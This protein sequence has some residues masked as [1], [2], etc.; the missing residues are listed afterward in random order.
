MATWIVLSLLFACVGA[1][2]YSVLPLG[3]DGEYIAEIKV[4]G[5]SFKLTL[6]TGSS[7]L[8]IP[9]QQ[10]SKCTGSASCSQGSFGDQCGC[11]SALSSS[12][13]EPVTC[14]EF[15]CPPETG[16]LTCGP[17]GIKLCDCRTASTEFPFLKPDVAVIVN[18]ECYGDNSGYYGV[19]SKNKVK[20][21]K[22]ETN[23]Y[24]TAYSFMI[25][26]YACGTSLNVGI[27][28]LAYKSI[29][30]LGVPG[31]LAQM[32]KEH[33]IDDVFAMC[34]VKPASEYVQDVGKSGSFVVGGIGP[35]SLYTGQVHYAAVVDDEFY[36]V[37][38]KDMQVNGQSFYMDMSGYNV[39]VDSGTT[40]LMLPSPVFAR[41]SNMVT[42]LND[43]VSFQLDGLNGPD[44]LLHVAYSDLNG[45]LA[46]GGNNFILGQPLFWGHHV[47]F[48]RTLNA[49]GFAAQGNCNSHTSS[50]SK[51]SS[52]TI[53]IAVALPL[54]ILAGGVAVY[55]NRKQSHKYEQ[56]IAYVAPE[57]EL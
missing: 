25:D 12:H 34:F 14:S 47:V 10:C 4:E 46:D 29:N 30:S 2:K 8:V 15:S 28:G 18:G 5:Q 36:S 48:N 54:I 45:N 20:I 6:D 9:V 44:V 33:E 41:L 53:A 43:V 57:E 52:S 3:Y 40:N 21:G 13:F 16:S 49:V 55:Y 42:D 23:A 31:P 19:V 39:I 22:F 27:L 11:L 38:L 24:F 32:V 7:N 17:P 56:S 50:K 1:G 37:S 26:E 51:A 35:S